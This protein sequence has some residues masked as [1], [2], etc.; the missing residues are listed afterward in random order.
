MKKIY[1]NESHIRQ[2]VK[3]TLENLILGEDD[4]ENTY[5]TDKMELPEIND[6]AGVVNFLDSLT[7]NGDS[8]IKSS[9]TYTNDIFEQEYYIENTPYGN[10]SIFIDFNVKGHWDGMYIPRDYGMGIE[11]EAPEAEI[12]KYIIDKIFINENEYEFNETIENSVKGH[13]ILNWLP[14]SEVITTI[15]EEYSLWNRNGYFSF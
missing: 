4:M 15:E 2:L 11:G 12:D 8:K 10:V 6:L 1:L 9:L 13:E 5:M 3:E 14:E 7:N